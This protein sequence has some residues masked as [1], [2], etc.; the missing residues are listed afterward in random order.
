MT[1]PLGQN[2][3]SEHASFNASAVRLVLGIGKH[4]CVEIDPNSNN[5]VLFLL[6]YKRWKEFLHFHFTQHSYKGDCMLTVKM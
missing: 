4:F 3:L 6:V 1:G 2:A 5:T